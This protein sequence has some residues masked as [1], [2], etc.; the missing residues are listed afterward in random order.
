MYG[1][2]VGSLAGRQAGSCSSLSAHAYHLFVCHSVC[3]SV[4]PL[5]SQ[6]GSATCVWR[7]SSVGK[8]AERVFLKQAK[9]YSSVVSVA[10]GNGTCHLLQT[11]LII[12]P[13]RLPGATGYSKLAILCRSID[14]ATY[15]LIKEN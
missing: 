14:L 8:Q 4:S 15:E 5:D 3:L 12:K 11:E 6:S 2:G 13:I 1:Y 10:C 9:L 7:C